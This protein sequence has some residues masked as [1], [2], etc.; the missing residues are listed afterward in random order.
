MVNVQRGK[1]KKKSADG[2]KEEKE[3]EKEK[4]KEHDTGPTVMTIGGI[5][6]RIRAA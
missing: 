5:A 1:K 6:R 2:E 4:E 3:K